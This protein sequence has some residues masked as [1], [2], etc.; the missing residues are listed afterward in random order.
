M[1]KNI[2]E[3]VVFACWKYVDRLTI[4]RALMSLDTKVA[5]LPISKDLPMKSILAVNYYRIGVVLDLDCPRSEIVLKQFSEAK[6]PYNESYFWLFVTNDSTPPVQCLE[7]LPL[8]IA[9]E[10]TVATRNYNSYILHDVYNPSYRHG[11]QL[12]VTKMG[13]WSPSRGL[14]VELTQYK[15]KRR[16]NLHGMYIN[17]SIAL[18]YPPVPDLMTYLTIPTNPH[19]DTM[20]RFHFNLILQLRDYYNFTMNLMRA[21]TWGYKVNGTFNGI[22]KDMVDGIVDVGAT[23]FMFK[24]ERIDVAEYTVQAWVARGSFFFRHPQRSEDGV[25]FLKPFKSEVW[26]FILGVG[27]IYWLFLLLTVRL[28]LHLTERKLECTLDSHPASESWLITTAAIT[29]QGLSDGPRFYSGRIVFIFLFL[30]GLL[31]FQFYSAS[32]VGSLLAEAPRFIVTLQDLSDSSLQLGVEDI[33]YNY[34]FFRTT[35]DPVA[36]EIYHKKIEANK[37]RKNNAFYTINEGLR[38]VQEGGFAFHADT[39]SAY[40][41]IEAT[42]SEQEICELSEIPLFPIQHTATLTSKHSPFKKMVTY[43]MRQ[44]V[45][46]GMSNRLRRHWYHRKPECPESHSS[47]PV[48]VPLEEF[49]P[50]IIFLLIGTILALAIMFA[51][52]QIERQKVTK[53]ETADRNTMCYLTHLGPWRI[54]GYLEY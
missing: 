7:K 52:S 20:H 46:R 31:L 25:G 51:E 8:T 28:E 41:I 29:Q 30:W 9:T 13:Y 14:T 21:S 39:A 5:Y 10:L 35:T 17:F 11:G 44:I 26:W 40:K 12:N 36:L 54:A 27:L 6:L 53:N 38:K 47:T 32:V 1:E 34:D 18:A 24:I 15:Y 4:S 50:A 42:F 33:G 19:L 49:S 37:K 43:G 3:I 23:P 48:P 45:E 2:H 22:L 16:G